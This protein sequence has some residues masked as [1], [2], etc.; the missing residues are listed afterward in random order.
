MTVVKSTATVLLLTAGSKTPGELARVVKVVLSVLVSTE[1][2]WLRLA[3]AVRGGSFRITRATGM[4]VP[5]STV[6]SWGK[7]PL[8][9]SQYVPGFP[10]T[11]LLA[12]KPP[13]ALLAA[14]GLPTAWLPVS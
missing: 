4:A 2:G 12:G 10:S 6:R 8:T 11:A 5:R 13:S 9:L 7:L 3:Q 14:T 1:N